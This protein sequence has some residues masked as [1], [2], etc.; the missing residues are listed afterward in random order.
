VSFELPRDSMEQV[1][2]RMSDQAADLLTRYGE[3][4]LEA[5][6]RV[7]LVSRASLDRLA[8]HFV[9]AA[10]ALAVVDAGRGTAVD[11]G[12]GGGLPG[13]VVW[14]LRPGLRMTLVEARRGKAAF[15]K[16]VRRELKIA[17]LEVVRGRLEDLVGRRRFDLALSRAVGSVERTLAPSL[18][19][20]GSGGRL[21]LFKGSRWSEEAEA[22][23]EIAGAEGAGIE[24]T[25][26]VELPGVGRTT[27]FVVFHVEHGER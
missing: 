27:T 18:R 17:N 16:R 22:A 2:G 12:S 10:A 24:R 3:L 9:D 11:L 6:T 20:V 21:V 7:N 26:D 14:V 23:A 4:V 25:V 1:A 5:S 13:V 8:D 19:L 15:L